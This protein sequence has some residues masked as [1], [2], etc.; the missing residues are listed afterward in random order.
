MYF[1]TSTVDSHESTFFRSLCWIFTF[2]LMLPCKGQLFAPPTNSWGSRRKGC[3]SPGLSVPLPEV[4]R[5]SSQLGK[6]SATAWNP[7]P[8]PFFFLKLSILCRGGDPELAWGCSGR[9]QKALA[10]GGC[11]GHLWAGEVAGPAGQGAGSCSLFGEAQG[12]WGAGVCSPL[13]NCPCLGGTRSVRRRCLQPPGSCPCL[14]G[15]RRVRRR[16]LQPPGS[17]PCLEG[18]RRVR[19]RCLQPPASC[20]SAWLQQ[21]CVGAQRLC[22]WVALEARKRAGAGIN[23]A[24][25][26]GLLDVFL[27]C[28]GR[29]KPFL[30][31]SAGGWMQWGLAHED[32]C[33]GGVR[34]VTRADAGYLVL[35]TKRGQN[36]SLEL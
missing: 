26:A 9:F 36:I 34:R 5:P 29:E 18:T 12:V 10:R 16:C 35:N 2:L 13:P 20:P 7:A 11:E 15:T 19:R 27:G 8:P 14:E 17:C 23:R 30:R 28:E 21:L 4:S 24:V 3:D 31:I 25:M 22:L 6:L 1:T 32:G 33:W